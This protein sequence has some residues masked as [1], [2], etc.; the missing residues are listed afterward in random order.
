MPLREEFERTGRWLF[1]RRSTLP[2]LVLAFMVAQLVDFHYLGHRHSMDLAWE[3]L[4]LA[5]GLLGLAL[6]IHV[7]GHAPHDTAGRNTRDWSAAELNTTGFYSVVR[8][9]LYL[10]NALMWLGV[11][12]FLH[13]LSVVL[14]VAMSFWLYYER[15]MFAEEEW[16]RGK[17]GAAYV[18]WAGRTPAFVPRPALW[19]PPILPFSPRSAI[20]R[21]YPGL[22]GLI[23]A[24]TLLE[25]AGDRVATGRLQLDPVW[26]VLLGLSV[27]IAVVAR[28]LKRHT[29]VLSVEG[30]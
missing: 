3:G 7:V 21:E 18:D 4:C 1:R 2:I 5:L 28:F 22:L 8:H 17:F 13:R 12:L 10:G 9:P 27:V 6:R 14:P 26:G 24:F 11:A 23:C 30:R 19:R 29:S 16:L 20:R 25:V 15:I